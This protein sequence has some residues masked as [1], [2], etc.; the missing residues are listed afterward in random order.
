MT[1]ES[2][3]ETDVLTDVAREC[4][5]GEARAL[6]A[7]LDYRD[8]EMERIAT[9]ESPMR[10][11]VERS[12]IPM[13]I[14]E[15]MRL[16]E[17][18]VQMRLSFADTV[19]DQ[20]PTS[21]AAF[22]DGRIDLARVRDIARTIDQLKRAES[23]HRLDRRVIAYAVEH[24]AAELRAWLR[25]FVIRVEPDLATERA[26]DERD[27]RHVSITHGDDSM[28]WIN[29][30]VAS[31]EA[32]AVAERLHTAA[33]RNVDPEDTRT[34]AQ[35]EADLLVAWCL[36][37][38]ATSSALSANIAVTIDADVLAG[39]VAGF[40]E[41]TDGQWAVPAWWMADVIASGSIFWHR[42][43]TE[44]VTK[45][46]L[47]HEYLGRFAPDILDVALQFLHG[48]CQAPGCMVPAGRCDQDHRVPHPEGPTS[49]SNMGPLCRRHHVFKGHSLLRWSSLKTKAPP[50]LVVEIYTSPV[51]MGWAA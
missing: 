28:A 13:A 19:R 29:A 36:E 20:S 9:I 6:T 48:V 38:D 14:G 30:Y 2:A 24:T 22:V 12:A 35:R 27:K 33:R 50:A 10:R 17:G 46:V 15:A 31:H 47:S 1:T 41:S 51:S 25:R 42:I 32:A 43:V 5:R 40:A 3:C 39:A 49:A 26:D 34:V 16:S 8:L 18:Q 11:L 4:A 21:W 23:I 45:D 37:S 7:M 44:P